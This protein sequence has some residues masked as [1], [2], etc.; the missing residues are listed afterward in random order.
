MMLTK[1]LHQ[2]LENSIYLILHRCLTVRGNTVEFELQP[3]L[4][5]SLNFE[6]RR[7]KDQVHF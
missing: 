1:I 7:G 6:W 2:E 5:K 4:E 3:N